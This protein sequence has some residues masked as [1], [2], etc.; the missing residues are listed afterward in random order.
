MSAL[1]LKPELYI[2]FRRCLCKVIK[3]YVL[4]QQF[5]ISLRKSALN[6]DKVSTRCMLSYSFFALFQ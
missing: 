3:M 4:Y 5:F 1:I 2:T 6:I